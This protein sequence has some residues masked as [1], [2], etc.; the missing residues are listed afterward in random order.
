MDAQVLTSFASEFF[1]DQEGISLKVRM[2]DDGSG[3]TLMRRSSAAHYNG[4]KS[5]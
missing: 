1:M 5:L 4:R 3:A 2:T